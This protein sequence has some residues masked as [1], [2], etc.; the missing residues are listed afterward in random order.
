M[1]LWFLQ[2]A[3]CLRGCR[4]VFWR[5][6]KD[7]APLCL[8][9]HFRPL[10]QSLPGKWRPTPRPPTPQPH[11]QW[12]LRD[13][14][15]QILKLSGT[16]RKLS[17]FHFF[18]YRQCYIRTFSLHFKCLSKVFPGATAPLHHIEQCGKVFVPREGRGRAFQGGLSQFS[19]KVCVQLADEENEQRRRQEQML[20]EKL[21]Q[22]EQQEEEESK[23]SSHTSTSSER[24]PICPQTSDEWPAEPVFERNRTT[25]FT[26]RW[27]QT[28]R[29]QPDATSDFPPHSAVRD[30]CWRS[31]RP[32]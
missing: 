26:H 24:P 11:P 18:I 13:G 10:H 22:E 17:N 28:F 32:L 12:S 14:K 30:C 7:H 3:G 8:L 2:T 4:Q 6:L 20:L 16:L 9:S 1:N 27:T 15:I 25:Q 29:L 5:E 19:L 31:T 21:E 23:V